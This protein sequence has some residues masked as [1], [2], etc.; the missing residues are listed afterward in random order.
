[1]FASFWLHLVELWNTIADASVLLWGALV[2]FTCS[3]VS[4]VTATFKSGSAFNWLRRLINIIG[5]NVH[6]AS[7]ADEPRHVDDKEKHI[8]S[9]KNYRKLAADL[10]LEIDNVKAA[11]KKELEE[12]KARYEKM[13]ADS[14]KE[15][16]AKLG[17]TYEQHKADMSAA[18]DKQKNALEGEIADL[19]A[20]REEASREHE[21]VVDALKK[22][23]KNAKT[24][25]S[26]LKSKVAKEVKAA[27]QTA[28]EYFDE[29]IDKRRRK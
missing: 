7:N 20:A 25:A 29:A 13:Y 2:S 1:M 10:R 8:N 4:A 26:R 9:A 28:S 19:K 5:L 14:V 18:F 22:Q 3:A 23:V 17:A 16:H 12:L 24:T 15:A 21:V 6:H 11:G 27:P